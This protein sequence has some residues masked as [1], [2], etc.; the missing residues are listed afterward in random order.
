MFLFFHT[1]TGRFQQY[2]CLVYPPELKVPKGLY[3]QLKGSRV[4]NFIF[5]KRSQTGNVAEVEMKVPDRHAMIIQSLR[6][7]LKPYTDALREHFRYLNDVLIIADIFMK[8]H[9]LYLQ[10]NGDQWIENFNGDL[11]EKVMFFLFIPSN[12]KY[13]ILCSLATTGKKELHHSY[14]H[15]CG[16]F[17]GLHTGFLW[18]GG[19]GGGAL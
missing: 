2:D 8:H 7:Y 18:W 3:D 12:S 13:K 11:L 14:I 9:S 6:F 15:S 19:G 16:G 10:Q 5:G 17:P 4:W 1:Y